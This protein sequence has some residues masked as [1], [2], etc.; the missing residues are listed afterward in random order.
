[1]ERLDK[2]SDFFIPP[3]GLINLS[4]QSHNNYYE[5]NYFEDNYNSK[6]YNVCY[7][8]SCIQCLFHLKYFANFLLENNG[9]SLSK[10]SFNLLLKMIKSENGNKTDFN[11]SVIE[12]KE[13]MSKIDQRYKKNNQE[14]VNEFISIYLYELL[15]ETADKSC[16]IKKLIIDNKY[17]K[18]AYDKLYCKFYLKNGYS[19]LMDLF[20]G[21]LK[22]EKYCKYCNN[23]I[24]IRFNIYNMIELPIYELSKNDL[25]KSLNLKDIIDNYLQPYKNINSLCNICKR[26]IYTRTKIYTYPKYLILYFGRTVEYEY[27]SN[28]INYDHL[29]TIDNIT[30]YNLA[31]VIYYTSFGYKI[32]HYSCSCKIDNKWYYFDDNNVQKIQKPENISGKVI[33]LFYEKIK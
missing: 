27:I 24:F 7:M 11:L 15:E 18:E 31:S 16:Q 25:Y 3:V 5:Y 28:D 32:G 26:E 13:A 9:K 8:N 1:M 6:L 20:Y 19:F 21:I 10:A 4:R 33:I 2:Y 23:L 17:E 29:L 30:F 14:D 22:I 12:I